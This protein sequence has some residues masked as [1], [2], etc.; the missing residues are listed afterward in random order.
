MD[1]N[2]I[3]LQHKFCFWWGEKVLLCT[4]VHEYLDIN[5]RGIYI[6]VSEPVCWDVIFHHVVLTPCRP[7]MLWIPRWRT[8]SSASLSC[9]RLTSWQLTAAFTPRRICELTRPLAHTVLLWV[10]PTHTECLLEPPIASL[11]CTYIFVHH[12][13]SVSRVCVNFVPSL[14]LNQP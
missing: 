2:R 3:S 11:V 14:R 1:S 4:M 7:L 5:Q 8:W 6:Y 9:Q 12:G 10:P 13:S